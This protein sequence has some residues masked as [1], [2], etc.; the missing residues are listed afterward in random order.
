EPIVGGGIF[1][2]AAPALIARFG[3]VSVLLMTAALLAFWLFMG[4]VVLK[5][6]IRQVAA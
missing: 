2:A 6:T 1:T 3:P 5:R 4:L